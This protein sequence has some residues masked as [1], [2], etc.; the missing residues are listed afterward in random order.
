MK[1][2]FTS[3]AA[4]TAACCIAL[5]ASAQRAATVSHQSGASMLVLDASGSMLRKIDGRTKIEIAREAVASMLDTWP[6]NRQL[7]LMAYG[8]RT[9]GDC[10][11]IE[12]L[13]DA[14]TVDAEGMQTA[15]NA[16]HPKG[17]TPISAAVRLAARH[18][19]FT[20]RR[21]TVILVSDGEETCHSDPCALGKDLEKLGVDFTTH[22]VGFD[23]P[24]GDARA[25]LQC[26]AESTGGRYVEA[27]DAAELNMALGELVA[28][29]TKKPASA[30]QPKRI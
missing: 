22:V 3:I 29:A 5:S 19:T 8:H 6:A 18:L 4:M 2:S 9:K 20:E 1:S 27:R 13:M 26:L 28:P 10:A 23:L 16:L 24:E 17:M 25:Q 11:D 21:A 14:D 15:V 30:A 12:L 7:G